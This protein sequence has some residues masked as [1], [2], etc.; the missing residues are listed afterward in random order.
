MANGDGWSLLEKR[1]IAAMEDYLEKCINI[2]VEIAALELLMGPKEAEVCLWYILKHAKRRGCGIFEILDSEERR[3]HF[4][5]SRIR[6]L[7]YQG[8]RVA[9]QENGQNDWQ[10]VK[11]EGQMAKAPPCPER[12]MKTPLPQQ[13]SSST[14]ERKKVSGFLCKRGASGASP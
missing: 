10:D 13:R 4:V 5:E 7:E 12:S 9:L 11:Y 1:L 14:R 2:Q 6:W 3:D 8:E